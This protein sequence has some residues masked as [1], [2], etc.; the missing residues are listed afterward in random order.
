[1]IIIN[2]IHYNNNNNNN[3]NPKTGGKV[4]EFFRKKVNELI[5]RLSLINFK[6]HRIFKRFAQRKFDKFQ[7]NKK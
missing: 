1:M 7:I 6:I 2:Q 5:S 3:N 4:N